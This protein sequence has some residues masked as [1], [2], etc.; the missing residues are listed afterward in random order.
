[1]T[2]SALYLLSFADVVLNKILEDSLCC[3]NAKSWF[4]YLYVLAGETKL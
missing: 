1:M 4:N 2:S 3:F